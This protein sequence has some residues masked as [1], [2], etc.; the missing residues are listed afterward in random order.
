MAFNIEHLPSSCAAH[1]SLSTSLNT[2]CKLK[3][4]FIW[5]IILS[6]NTPMS[7][8]EHIIFS[9]INTCNYVIFACICLDKNNNK[10]TVFNYQNS[11]FSQKLW[12]DVKNKMAENKHIKKILTILSYRRG[13]TTV[14][15][16]VVGRRWSSRFHLWLRCLCRSR[17][18]R[19]RRPSGSVLHRLSEKRVIII[20]LNFRIPKLI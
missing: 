9:S 12:A 6:S 15:R 17:W 2:S 11:L 18:Q 5:N 19:C 10:Q 7:I 16:W 4:I 14:D 3:T 13:S 1:A 20:F 8:D